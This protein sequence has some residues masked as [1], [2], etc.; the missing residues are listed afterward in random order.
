MSR[1][2]GVV[3]IL[4]VVSSYYYITGVGTRYADPFSDAKVASLIKSR[5][6]LIPTSMV[7]TKTNAKPINSIQL[8]ESLFKSWVFLP[9]KYIFKLFL[10]N[11]N[12]YKLVK[13]YYIYGIFKVE[14]TNPNKVILSWDFFNLSGIHILST[15]NEN[16][17]FETIFWANGSV[18]PGLLWF[19]RRYSEFLLTA[20]VNRSTNS[21]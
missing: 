16:S 4:G 14:E 6:D 20:A 15:T 10:K 3:G 8:T 7:F 11:F 13:D 9:E 1:I 2:I 5:T 21:K 12:D 17:K 18:I 19:H